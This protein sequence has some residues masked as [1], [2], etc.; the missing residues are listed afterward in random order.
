MPSCCVPGTRTWS[1]PPPLRR[2]RRAVGKG[3]GLWVAW[4]AWNPGGLP[5]SRGRGQVYSWQSCFS[6]VLT[7]CL[8]PTREDYLEDP[9][10]KCSGILS[11]NFVAPGGDAKILTWQLFPSFL[12]CLMGQ[13]G[14]AIGFQADSYPGSL[15]RDQDTGGAQRSWRTGLR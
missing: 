13:T 12:L 2:S 7:Q 8:C 15:Y 10:N 14:S 11:F 3:A 4:G 1:Y 6:W 5:G 9:N